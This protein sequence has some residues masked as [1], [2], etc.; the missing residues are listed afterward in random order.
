MIN[1][2]TQHRLDTA[3]EM[4]AGEQALL[5][6]ATALVQQTI[7]KLCQLTGATYNDKR[8]HRVNGAISNL[9]L[10]KTKIGEAR[11]LEPAQ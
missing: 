6:E 9:A 8:F 10:A 1:P 3:T 5:D 4:N 2:A 11:A 7:D